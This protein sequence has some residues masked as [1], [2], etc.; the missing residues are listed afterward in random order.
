MYASSVWYARRFHRGENGS[1][2]VSTESPRNA[3]PNST[4]ARVVSDSKRCFAAPVSILGCDPNASSPRRGSHSLASSTL[5]WP[6]PMPMPM[7]VL[8]KV[9]SRG[10]P[11]AEI[12]MEAGALLEA[13]LELADRTRLEVRVLSARSAAVDF[14]PR[15][16][17]RS[18]APSVVMIYAKMSPTRAAPE[19]VR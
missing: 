7:L 8:V 19:P 11:M 18:A 5:R 4:S 10:R 13:L 1:R 3:G 2:M 9:R 6:M 16:V 12:G 15:T 14:S 17:Y